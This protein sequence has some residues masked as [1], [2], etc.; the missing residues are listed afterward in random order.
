MNEF[1]AIGVAVSGMNAAQQE[2]DVT[3]NN[4]ANASTPG[5]VRERADLAALPP[6]T[7]T[8]LM[9]SAGAGQGVTVLGITR[10]DD[11]YADAQSLTAQGNAAQ[12]SQTQSVLGQA[13]AAFNEPGASGISSQ[14]SS[15]WSQWDAV[16]NNPTNS[17]ARS[18]LVSSAGALA[19]TFN[20]TAAALDQ[21]RAGASSGAVAD[22]A[23]V[24]RD[25]SQVAQLNS[26]IVSAQAGGG[27]R[28]AS[29]TSVTPSSTT[30]PR[31]WE[32]PRGR[33]RAARSTCWSARRRW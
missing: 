14:L 10:L 24:N 33:R 16:A 27:T 11:P 15:F 4:I 13:Q 32:P 21:V 9:R 23:E 18:T 6:P 2:L 28:P 26:E 31:W 30:S 7:P 19:T 3:G 8:L 5:Y 1:A 25:A 17:A 22:V 20:Q 12:A 29:P